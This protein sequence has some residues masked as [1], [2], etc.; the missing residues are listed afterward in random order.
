MV[1]N[2][3]ALLVQ[4]FHNTISFGKWPS[5]QYLAVVLSDLLFCLYY[6]CI[7]KLCSSS[8]MWHQFLTLN[9]SKVCRD[10]G[11]KMVALFPFYFLQSKP[12]LMYLEFCLLFSTALYSK[13]RGSGGIIVFFILH[14]SWPYWIDSTSMWLWEYLRVRKQS[15]SYWQYFSSCLTH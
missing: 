11:Y 2:L 7:L 14:I 12:K 13:L 8:C 6:T 9:T 15:S 10:F 1:S 5:Q 3:I 4:A